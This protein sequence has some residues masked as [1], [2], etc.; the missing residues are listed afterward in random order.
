MAVVP[1]VILYWQGNVR[2]VRDDSRRKSVWMVFAEL[3]FI[4]SIGIVVITI[5]QR[6]ARNIYVFYALTSVYVS[7]GGAVD[8]HPPNK[9]LSEDSTFILLFFSS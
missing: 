8:S 7:G 4:L 2:D 5:P 6:N 1:I 9:K 3:S